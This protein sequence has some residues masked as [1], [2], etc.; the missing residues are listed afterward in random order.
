LEVAEDLA[1][2]I[3]VGIPVSCGTQHVGSLLEMT[4]SGGRR[5]EE[6][7]DVYLHCVLEYH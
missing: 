7:K 3:R 6:T 5:E 2:I 1:V 4:A